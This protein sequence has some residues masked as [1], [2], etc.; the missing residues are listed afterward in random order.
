MIFILFKGIFKTDEKY[1]YLRTALKEI[2]ADL[3][4]LKTIKINQTNYTI[5]WTHGGDLKWLAEIF[6]INAA[7]SNQPCPWCL[8]N[9]KD[10]F[11]DSGKKIIWNEK[12]NINERSTNKPILKKA[13][14]N[15]FKNYPIISFLDYNQNVIDILHLFLRITD[16]IFKKFLDFLN[17]L[18][19]DYSFDLDKRPNLK[20]LN[21]YLVDV[22]KITKPLYLSRKGILKLR[23]LNEKER[24][25]ILYKEKNETFIQ[26]LFPKYNSFGKKND[27]KDAKGKMEAFSIVFDEFNNIYNYIKYDFNEYEF[28]LDE[29]RSKMNTWIS[30]FIVVNGEKSITPYIHALIFHVS[31]FIIKYKNLNLYSLQQLEK[32]G[33]ITKTNFFRSTN[34]QTNKFNKLLLE[35]INRIELLDLNIDPSL[36]EFPESETLASEFSDSKQDDKFHYFLKL[37]NQSNSCYANS[38]IQALLSL[39]N[40]FFIMVIEKMIFFDIFLI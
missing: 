34:K 6:G 10:E 9:K 25:K 22:C 4:K 20:Q 1:S 31:E 14:V 17:L 35:K 24:L 40:P 29:Y 3:S 38:C 12:W 32:L 33:S 11:I 16:I 15:G 27:N 19:N 30:Y 5:E 18:D 39:G 37:N 2:I 23:S 7:N 28:D 26:K 21:D 8:W 13:K 36:I